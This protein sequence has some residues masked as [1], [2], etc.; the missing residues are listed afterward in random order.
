MSGS[1]GG[2]DGNLD[3]GARVLVLVRVMLGGEGADSRVERELEVSFASVWGGEGVVV[4]VGV[5][6]VSGSEE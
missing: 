4:L 5:D 6:G 3:T 2:M 1:L